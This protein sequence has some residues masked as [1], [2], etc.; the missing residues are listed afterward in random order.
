LVRRVSRKLRIIRQALILLQ[1]KIKVVVPRSQ[2]I[3][4]L[5]RL[6]RIKSLRVEEEVKNA[7]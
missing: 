6:F 5:L 1:V 7:Y 2:M 4:S 3:R